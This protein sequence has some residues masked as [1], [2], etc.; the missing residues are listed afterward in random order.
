MSNEKVSREEFDALRAQFDRLHKEAQLLSGELHREIEEDDLAF[1]GT[2][3]HR[4][5]ELDAAI[6]GTQRRDVIAEAAQH[7][8]QENARLR[9]A[10]EDVT[11][12]FEIWAAEGE[13]T[14]TEREVE[15]KVLQALGKEGK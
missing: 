10:L 2:G 12:V 1:P 9:Q 8:A 5:L 11:E 7:L 15:T 6:A 13:L 3:F 4:L 14:E